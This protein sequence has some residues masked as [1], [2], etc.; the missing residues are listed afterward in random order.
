[1]KIL[2]ADKFAEAGIA[3][4][5][6]QGNQVVFSPDLKDASLTQ[7]IEE[8]DPNILIVRSTK[9]PGPMI[10]NAKALSLIVRAG[11]GT[12]TIDVEQAS[13][14]GVYVANCPGKNSVAVAELTFGLIL[15]LDRK[16]PD[17]VA[18][19]RA[20]KWNKK[21]FSS[22]SGVFGKTLGLIGLGQIGQEVLKRAQAFGMKV[23]AYSRSLTIE[24]AETLGIQRL[25]SPKE[26]AAQADI[27]SVHLA[28][29]SETRGLCDEAFFNAM[30]DHSIFINTS[31]GDV[32]V[33][34]AL[35]N[36]MNNKGIQAGLDVF[37][38]EPQN[39]QDDFTQPI[40]THEN[41]YGTHHIGAST[42]QAQDAIADET[43]RII[44]AYVKTGIA[45]NVVNLCEKSPAKFLLSVRH[46]DRVG[47]LAHVLSSLK[48]ANINVQ[49][50]ENIVFSGAAAACAQIQLE[51]APS[52]EL[53][54]TI[55]SQSDDIYALNLFEI[56]GDV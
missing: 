11:A 26:V 3:A 39:S 55:E 24:Q 40:G 29:T 21:K 41:L 31:R 54:K 20:G 43:I 10:S 13:Q 1:V 18:V 30:R 22:A 49:E 8:H 36:A 38:N 17:N 50:M 27:V 34:S 9:V 28:L 37:E 14:K 4:L 5:E 51:L 19:L 12:N 23:I 7:S 32:V 35:L 52:N 48:K 2:I 33:Q 16:I 6:L 42:E 56:K 25:A 44:E 45:P 15:S 53:L 46:R 47:V